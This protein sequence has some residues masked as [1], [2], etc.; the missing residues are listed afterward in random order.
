MTRLRKRLGRAALVLLAVSL[1]PALALAQRKKPVPLD[2]G[3]VGSQI[4]PTCAGAPEGCPNNQPSITVDYITGETYQQARPFSLRYCDDW[5]LGTPTATLNGTSVPLTVTTISG[6]KAMK[7][8]TGTLSLPFGVSTLS[9]SV[10]DLYQSYL[11]PTGPLCTTITRQLEYRTVDVLARTATPT[12]V[13]SNQSGRTAVFRVQNIGTTTRTYTLTPVCTGTGVSG[14][15]SSLGNF[16]LNANDTVSATVSF[17]TGADGTTGS[18]SLKAAESTQSANTSTASVAVNVGWGATNPLVSAAPTNGARFE[19]AACAADC[20]DLATSYA[21]PAYV[22]VGEHRSVTLNYRGAR[23][24]PRAVVQLDVQDTSGIPASQVWVE[25]LDPANALVSFANGTTRLVY[26]RASPLR[27][28]AMDT[29]VRATGAYTYTAQVTSWWPDGITRR[30]TIP[31]RVLINNGQDSPYGA[32]WDVA[33]LERITSAGSDAI[34]VTGN[35]GIGYYTNSGCNTTICNFSSPAGDFSTLRKFVSDSSGVRWT[36]AFRNGS[37]MAYDSLGRLKQSRDRR[38][39]GS[40]LGYDAVN[41]RLIQLV[42]AIGRTTTLAYAGSG[43]AK[44]SSLQ[45]IT[46]PMGRT[47]NYSVNASNDLARITDATGAI[48]FNGTYSGHWLSSYTDRGNGQWSYTRGNDGSLRTM[49]SPTVT[50]GGRQIRLQTQIT[51][52]TSVALDA[53]AGG[54]GTA[55]NPLPALSPDSAVGRV[56]GPG[57]LTTSYLVGSF[58]KPTRIDEPRGK[59]TTITY[60]QNGLPLVYQS[61]SDR[62]VYTYG[63]GGT[64]SSL[65]QG[66]VTTTTDY[67]TYDLPVHS[68]GGGVEKFYTYDSTYNCPKSLRIG[69]T[70]TKVTTFVCDAR[71]R[72]VQVTDPEGHRTSTDYDP[73]TGNI[74][75]V[76]AQSDTVTPANRNSYTYYDRFGRDSASVSPSGATSTRLR[77]LLNRDTLVSSPQGLTVVTHYDSLYVKE[78]LIAGQRYQYVANAVGWV[79]SVTDVTGTRSVEYDSTGAII[80]QVN[81]RGQATRFTIDQYGRPLTKTL[82]DGRTIKYSYDPLDHWIADS[83]AE[84]I[85]TVRTDT[86]GRLQSARSYR[87]SHMFE[88]TYAYTVNGQ[89]DY[90]A[91]DRDGNVSPVSGHSIYAYDSAS[92]QQGNGLL[93]GVAE[94]TP[95]SRTT[96]Y[97]N[98]D[99]LV[100]RRNFP[101]PTSASATFSYNAEDRVSS[102]QFS[103]ILNGP[104]SRSYG[105]DKLG[106][107]VDRFNSDQT[108][109]RSFEYDLLGR[110]T[111][112]TDKTYTSGTCHPQVNV[113][114]VCTPGTETIDATAVLSYDVVGNR[115]DGSAITDPG[116]RLRSQNTLALDYDQDGNVVRR[117]Y[118]GRTDSL[119]WNSEN[120]L[121]SVRTPNGTVSFG[122]DGYGRRVRKTLNGASTR[123]FY[124]EDHVYAETNAIGDITRIYHYYPG[125]DAPAQMAMADGS[126][127]HFIRDESNNVVGVMN[128]AGKVV[129]QYNYAPFGAL[130]AT[131]FDSVPGGGNELRFKGRVW[132]SETGLYENRARYYDAVAGRF[133]SED[134]AGIAGGANPYT[135]GENDPINA[136]DPSGLTLNAQVCIDWYMQ[137]YLN[138]VLIYEEYLYTT[139]SGS[140]TGDG[141][142]GTQQAARNQLAQQR[143]ADVSA[144]AEKAC[145]D[146][147]QRAVFSYAFDAGTLAGL[148]QI[149]SSVTTLRTAFTQ[150]GRTLA[151][152]T[153]QIQAA[154]R[155][156]TENFASSGMPL[157]VGALGNY[158]YNNNTGVLQTTINFTPGINGSDKFFDELRTCTSEPTPLVSGRVHQR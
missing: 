143:F 37:L 102:A 116:N 155:A 15:P 121:D 11:T 61:P 85:D 125:V 31:V 153:A 146:A 29:T 24:Q 117:T 73:V 75:H 110:L 4:I 25:L 115:T 76:A 38:G 136:S 94:Q 133:L 14:C 59:R 154:W 103:G 158:I 100:S 77:D 69:A 119:F 93:Y 57:G 95:D 9:T 87:V 34:L 26:T 35:G 127:Y 68:N 128:N 40:T 83:S 99:G 150:T 28:V 18:V 33:G 42:D 111:K 32:G 65:Q 105:W 78:V 134:P 157:V 104:F 148:R 130:E 5:G 70:A 129:A 8:A 16:V 132:D 79:Q 13:A 142:G 64:V 112:T 50:A 54:G 137:Y 97:H 66:G 60:D 91:F 113:G 145:Y 144:Q 122:Y 82:A 36:R 49:L 109:G 3:S 107:I 10:C 51:S 55:S 53:A 39:Y 17:N 86:Y 47:T 46:D 12:R 62:V 30:T 2:T 156:L 140:T 27:V 72:I 131:S 139:C 1:L 101:A 56:I 151:Q 48:V 45:S 141:K 80:T 89:L 98:A 152:R 147:M 118:A 84:G 106:R 22:S 67:G 7:Q 123:Y 124:D 58:N 44:P 120:Q 96:L 126:L 71:G 20:F 81:K 19:P 92:V 63:A 23:A 52:P 41:G 88:I 149:S 90:L 21:I 138:G 114:M 74:A 108:K 6:C 135:F 43:A